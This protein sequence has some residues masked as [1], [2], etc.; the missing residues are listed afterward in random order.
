[1][2]ALLV[3]GYNCIYDLVSGQ[4]EQYSL[5]S[6]APWTQPPPQ[7]SCRLLAGQTGDLQY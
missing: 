5:L 7:L 4:A 3:I 1:M 6:S 2:R